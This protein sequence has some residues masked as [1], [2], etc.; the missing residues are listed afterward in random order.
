MFRGSNLKIVHLKIK[1]KC[2]ERIAEQQRLISSGDNEHLEKYVLGNG[3]VC[4][5]HFLK[6]LRISE[7]PSVMEM[8]LKLH[9]CLA[10]KM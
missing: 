1:L 3:L 2:Q 10:F 9:T 5:S 8:G 7:P 6:G 4:A